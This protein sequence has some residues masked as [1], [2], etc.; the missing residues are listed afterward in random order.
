MIAL[1]RRSIPRD[2]KAAPEDRFVVGGYSYGPVQ[3]PSS[4]ASRCL[5]QLVLGLAAA[6]VV[7]V[8]ESRLLLIVALHMALSQ[9]TALLA[10]WELTRANGLGYWVNSP[11]PKKGRGILCNP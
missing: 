6:I 8:E 3:A 7:D 5:G 11:R 1:V 4:H 9:L 2:G 10:P